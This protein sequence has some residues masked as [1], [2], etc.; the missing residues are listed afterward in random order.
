MRPEWWRGGGLIFCFQRCASLSRYFVPAALLALFCLEIYGDPG[1]NSN[2][3][4]GRLII[5]QY[6]SQIVSM[7]FRSCIGVLYIDL[8][9]SSWRR[10]SQISGV[11]GGLSSGRAAATSPPPVRPEKKKSRP[12]AGRAFTK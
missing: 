12:A 10:C 8:I 11:N 6:L 7:D 5:P 3:A 2:C 9:R 4:P 1:G